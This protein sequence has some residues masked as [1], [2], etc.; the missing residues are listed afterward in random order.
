V[1]AGAKP[2]PYTLNDMVKDAVALLD[3]LKIDKAHIVGASMG[4]MIVQLLAADYPE[5]VLSLTSI[6]ADPRPPSTDVIGALTALPADTS[7]DASVENAVRMM[8]AIGSPSCDYDSPHERARFRRIAERSSYAAGIP[9]QLAAVFA[10]GDL[11]PKLKK[12]RAPTVVIHGEIDPLVPVSGG[13]E[14]AAHITDA[15]LVIVPGLGHE[16]SPF[17][18]DLITQEILNVAD[19]AS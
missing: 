2:A 7:V 15:K 12:V 18:I 16:V 1:I 14:T 19:K 11:R 3:V 6:M 17:A 5:R 9:R 8:K 4:G 10:T 13:R